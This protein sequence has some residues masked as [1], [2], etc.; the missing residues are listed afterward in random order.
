M[1]QAT[2][3]VGV[4][5]LALSA[6][7]PAAGFAGV[8]AGDAQYNGADAQELECS[9]PVT[10]TDASGTEVTVEE[11]PERVVTLSPSAAQTMWEIGAREK[12]VGVSQFAGFLEGADSREVVTSGFPS[13]VNTEKVIDLNP[14]LV[15]APNTIDNESVQQLRDADVTVYRF[16]TATSIENVVQKT[17]TIGELAAACDGASDTISEMRDRTETVEQAVDGEDEPRVFYDL[18]D[19]FTAGPNTFIGQVIDRAGG[20]NI[21]ADAN[22]SRLYPQLSAEF[23]VDQDPEYVVVSASPAQLGEDPRSYIGNDSVVRNTTAWE[24][25]NIVV[26]NTNHINQPAPRIVEPMA[27][28]AA[29]FHSAAYAD[30]NTTTTTTTTTQPTTAA[31]TTAATTDAEMTTEAA[32]TAAPTTT[33]SEDTGTTIP[34]FG[35]G[36]A[37]VALLGAVLFARR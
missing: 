20:Q 12:V 25:G 34:G 10:S 17:E 8:P 3:L 4:V 32:T 24:E 18:G 2:I 5:L 30:A 36:T 21:A 31:E 35:I 33:E 6:A 7:A 1:R 15:I 19:R 29:A 13:T 28:M 37:I 27:Q 11:A 16:G 26:V 22:S 23:V 14:D 9:F